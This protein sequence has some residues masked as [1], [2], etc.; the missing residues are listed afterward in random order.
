MFANKKIAQI[1]L[2][3]GLSFSFLYAAI[4]SFINPF[5]WIGFFPM[6]LRSALP[7]NILL[8]TF[9]IVEIVVALWLL[10]GRQ[11]F[12]AA[13]V[14]ALMLA[15]IVFFNLASFDIVFR[16]VTILLAALALAVLENDRLRT[17]LK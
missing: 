5:A 12:Y 1:L 10:S 14:S 15:G 17:K 6:W 7:D 9:S 13:L 2:R 4:F 11:T 16:D 8:A 3:I